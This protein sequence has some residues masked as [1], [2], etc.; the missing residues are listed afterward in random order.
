MESSYIKLY[1]TGELQKRIKSLT[2]L[3]TECVLCPRL[4][5]VN[6]LKGELGSC[7]A[8]VKAVVSSAFPHFGEEAPLVGT[9]GSG[10]IFLTHCN[11]RCTFCQ[12]Y[13]ISHNG[14]GEPVESEQLARC[15]SLLQQRGC[16][17]INFV[18]PTHF[19]PQIIAALPKA[20]ELGLNVPLVY[21]CGGYESLQVIKLLDGIFDIYMPDSKFADEKYAQKYM[22]APDYF[23][24]LKEVL[25]EMHRQAGILKLDDNG[26]AYRGLLI[27][28]LVM[29]EGIAGSS[30][31]LSFIANELSKDSYVNIMSQYHPCY[32]ANYD[33]TINRRILSKEYSQAIERAKEVG[34]YRGF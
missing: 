30:Q 29:P 28:H 5:K 19:V 23:Q 12:N 9:R 20:I 32:E 18:T 15:M 34:L 31:I 27:R 24:V 11:L 4:C 25:T 16:H 13:E 17:N 3:L 8:G 2:K 26:I 22:N 6:R 14:E 7:K 10:T 1:Q 21:N 33:K